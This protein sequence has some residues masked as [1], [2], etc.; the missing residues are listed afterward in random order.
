MNNKHP[1]KS[2][3]H[4][5]TSSSTLVKKYHLEWLL[6]FKTLREGIQEKK[7]KWGIIISLKMENIR[8][9]SN[10][11]HLFMY[12]SFGGHSKKSSMMHQVWMMFDQSFG[13][14]NKWNNLH[15]KLLQKPSAAE[16]VFLPLYYNTHAHTRAHRHSHFL[17]AE[18]AATQTQTQ[19]SKII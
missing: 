9:S 7:E 15:G 6:A 11:R 5:S 19:T 17:T 3:T 18:T 12:C 4:T 8:P 2:P 14:G 10:Q 16:S 13:S 1:D